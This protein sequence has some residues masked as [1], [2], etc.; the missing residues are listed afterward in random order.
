MGC[1]TGIVRNMAVPGF[2]WHL[3]QKPVTGVSVT[4]ARE[5]FY[6]NSHG[7]QGSFV[8]MK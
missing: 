8:M 6:F 5:W 7:C 1:V 4:S 3:H 2:H